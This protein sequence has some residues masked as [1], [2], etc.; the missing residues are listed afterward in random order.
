MYPPRG[1]NCPYRFQAESA[2]KTQILPEGRNRCISLAGFWEPESRTP[3]RP[4]AQPRWRSHAP[5][6]RPPSAPHALEAHPSLSGSKRGPRVGVLRQ[7]RAS[8]GIP[9]TGNR[10]NLSSRKLSTAKEQAVRGG[11]GKAP[12]K[13]MEPEQMSSVLML[14]YK[15]PL[16]G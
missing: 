16:L 6:S 7:L 9:C 5:R 14:T 4:A 8:K 2:R 13:S 3:R 1:R 12:C 11:G 15:V 10:K